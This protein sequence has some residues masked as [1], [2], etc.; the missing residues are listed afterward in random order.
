MN[1]ASKNLDV[2]SLIL[3]FEPMNEPDAVPKELVSEVIDELLKS[4]PIRNAGFVSKLRKTKT[5]EDLDNWLVELYD[6]CDEK[7]IFIDGRENE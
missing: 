7:K 6:F 2:V 5:V 4:E 1:V 3:Q